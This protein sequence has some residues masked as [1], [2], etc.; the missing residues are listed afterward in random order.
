MFSWERTIED[1][2]ELPS[3]TALRLAAI[4]LVDT[5]PYMPVL[6]CAAAFWDCSSAAAATYIADFADREGDSFLT[7]SGSAGFAGS[8]GIG[9]R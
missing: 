2:C 3:S 5:E 7:G 8:A 4:S 6:A 1:P 9:T